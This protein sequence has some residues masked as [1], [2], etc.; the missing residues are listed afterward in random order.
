MAQAPSME[1]NSS[2]WLAVAVCSALMRASAAAAII[3][4]ILEP[5]GGTAFTADW[6]LTLPPL[7]TLPLARLHL[8]VHCFK[9]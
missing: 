8:H 6:K 9:Q 4:R 7:P 2:C 3:S 1:A 5:S